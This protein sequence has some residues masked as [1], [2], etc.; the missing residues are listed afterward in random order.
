MLNVSNG[1]S[2]ALQVLRSRDDIVIK[3]AEKG[4][5]IVV[6]R[7]DLYIEEAYRQ[8]SDVTFYKK[9]EE[10]FTLVNNDIVSPSAASLIEKNS[11]GSVLE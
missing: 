10:D 1:E 6:W 2:V 7:K 5:S 11:R 8:H 4:G 3:K 9:A